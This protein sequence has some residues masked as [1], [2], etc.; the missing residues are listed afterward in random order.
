MTIA[1]LEL[2][3]TATGDTSALAGKYLTF[4]LADEEYGVPVLKVREIMKVLAITGVPQAPPHVKGVINLRGKVIPVVDLRLKFGFPSQAY[5]ERT[6]IIVVDVVLQAGRVMMGV[7]VDAV[8]E[9]LTIT[10]DEIEATPDFGEHVNTEFMQ[11]V[12][13]VKGKVKFLLDLD[14]IFGG[15]AALLEISSASSVASVI[16]QRRG[17]DPAGRNSRFQS[18][19]LVWNSHIHAVWAS[20]RISSPV[21]R[22]SSGTRAIQ[23]RTGIITRCGRQK[24]NRSYSIDRWRSR[25]TSSIRGP[26]RGSSRSGGPTVAGILRL[27]LR[28]VGSSYE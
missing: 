23:T 2:E 4:A 21:S 22:G 6:C 26:R 11:G 5:D 19:T 1:T 8:S 28:L 24:P 9:V 14:R 15:T 25:P 16:L 3:S 27:C 12:A 13:K 17:G 20:S 18:L 10:A 7:V